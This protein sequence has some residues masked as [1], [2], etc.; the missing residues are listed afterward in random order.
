M[1][2][3]MRSTAI[4]IAVCLV[5]WATPP[6]YAQNVTTGSLTGVVKDAQ[7]GVLPGATVTAVHEP[8]GT[9]YETVTEGDGR[10]QLLHVR[11]GGPYNVTISLQGFKPL[12]QMGVVAKLGEAT[13]IPVQ[14]QIETLTETVEVRADAASA[15]FT[16]SHAGAAANISP[17]AIQELPTIQRNLRLARTSPYSTRRARAA[18]RS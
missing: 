11:V 14:L 17:E 13:S 2:K 16:P 9:S 18:T 12:M 8:T 6:A 5:A 7:G 1:M 4:A 15:V 10:F 3:H